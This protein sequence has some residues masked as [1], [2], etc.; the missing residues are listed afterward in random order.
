LPAAV[1]HAAVPTLLRDATLR[2]AVAYASGTA[3][4]A[5]VLSARVI[6]LTEGGLKAMSGKKLSLAMALLLVLGVLG[7]GA[8]VIAHYTAEQDQDVEVKKPTPAAA[9]RPAAKP[10]TELEKLAGIWHVVAAERRGKP[11]PL[12]RDLAI[13]QKLVVKGDLFHEMDGDFGP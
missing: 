9:N 4:G 3:L 11:V 12:D 7:I 8:A 2:A 5:G 6:Q 13:F 10:K 1:S